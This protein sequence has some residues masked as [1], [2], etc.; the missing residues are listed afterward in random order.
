MK[1][2]LIHG[3]VGVLIA[4]ILLSTVAPLMPQTLIHVNAQTAY[5]NA[6]L[7]R[8]APILGN[9]TLDQ[10]YLE[11]LLE[12]LEYNV[13]DP[14]LKSILENINKSL[15]LGDMESY[16]QSVKELGGYLENISSSK[17]VD[18]DPDVLRD[19]ALIA[20][21]NPGKN[22]FQV[23]LND[24]LRLVNTLYGKAGREPV[25]L[26]DLESS[27]KG[28]RGVNA[29]SGGSLNASLPNIPIPSLETGKTRGF[30]LPLYTVAKALIYITVLTGFV[31][32]AY[33]RRDVLEDLFYRSILTAKHRLHGYRMDSND[34]RTLI[35]T[36]FNNLVRILRVKG[37]EKYEWETVREFTRRVTGNRIRDAVSRAVHVYE[38]ARYSGKP[39]ATSDLEECNKSVEEVLKS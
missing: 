20:S 5:S 38:K 31:Y 32:L 1:T 19:L 11:E 15:S 3:R 28:L 29:S 18:L 14:D 9:I 34:L 26:G 13:T 22:G 2:L 16:N 36:C 17:A 23:D 30:S 33:I 12:S 21:S 24:Y 37:I 7:R 39:L 27:L 10:K 8:H 35:I 6:E 4:V 25:S